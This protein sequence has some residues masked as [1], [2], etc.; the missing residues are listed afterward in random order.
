MCVSDFCVHCYW[1]TDQRRHNKCRVFIHLCVFPVIIFVKVKEF[2]L[3][4]KWG[5]FHVIPA[6]Q[7]RTLH[8][9][10][11]LTRSW[12]LRH[13]P[14]QPGWLPA[15]RDKTGVF[16]LRTIEED[17][18]LE[19]GH[20]VWSFRQSLF[21]LPIEHKNLFCNWAELHWSYMKRSQITLNELVQYPSLIQGS[22]W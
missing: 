11:Q 21:I 15:Y 18:R 14:Q 20:A 4:G 16:T 22:N 7:I 5:S 13:R 1:L 17:D 8:R 6:I 9:F 12:D 10:P 3:A 2:P 19:R